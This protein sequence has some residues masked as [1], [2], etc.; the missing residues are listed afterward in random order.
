MSKFPELAAVA[1]AVALAGPAAAQSFDLGRPATEAEVAAWDIDIRPDGM[2]LPEGSGD[3]WTGEELYVDLCASC[4]GDFGEARGRWPVLAGGDG[5]LTDDRPVKTIGSYW[6]Y[7]STVWDYVHRAMPFGQ[8]QMLTDDEVYAITAYLLY[9][10]Y[11]VED[12]FTLSHENFTEV[13]LPNEENFFLD[14]R[15]EAELAA[16]SDEVCMTDCKDAVEIT[17]RAA[18]VDVTPD[19]AAARERREAAAAGADAGVTE[20]DAAEEVVEA[21]AEEPAVD[22]Q[23]VADGEK[24]FAKCRACHQVGEGAKNR[25]GPHLNGVI[26]RLAGSIEGFRYSR[27]FQEAHDEG[28]TWTEETLAE[29]LAKPRTYIKGTKMSFAGFRQDEDIDAVIAYLSTFE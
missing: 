18:V 3:V 14:D 1:L 19:D 21:A 20:T 27:A 13:R 9:L 16:F 26:G 22:P 5:T 12:D 7:L 6:P 28:L 11:I 23:L 24:A 15:A 2:G 17:A 8:A 29:F 10:N 25:S 4:H